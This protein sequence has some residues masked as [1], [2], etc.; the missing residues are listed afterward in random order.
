MNTIGQRIRARRKELGLTQK[1]VASDVGVSSVAVTQWEGD[2]NAPRGDNLMKLASALGCSPDFILGNQELYP[3]DPEIG[4]RIK[5][6]REDAGLTQAELKESVGW[7]RLGQRLLN[8]EKG[9]AEP[10]Y[11]ELAELARALNMN[12]AYLA[13]GAEEMAP[14]YNPSVSLQGTEVQLP[15][16]VGVENL[17]NPKETK[18]FA[19]IELAKSG[20]KSNDAV[21][22]LMDGNTM[23]PYIPAGSELAVDT[24]T[25]S[26]TDGEMYLL[27][28]FNMLRVA[29]VYNVPGGYRLKFANKQDWPAEEIKGTDA[30][31]V[32]VIG[33]VFWYSVTR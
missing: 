21:L 16:F 25:T 24:S 12:A 22:T 17:N 20:V 14:K 19:P 28:Q 3:V 32:N 1:R 7:S 5:K 23:A 9:V 31:E 13:F 6:A 18:G 30:K 26:V 2:E 10:S 15:F 11:R 29:F 33:R 27:Q 8:Y 4:Q